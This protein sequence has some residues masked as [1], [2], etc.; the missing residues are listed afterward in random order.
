[1]P[2]P[3]TKG[4][5]PSNKEEFGTIVDGWYKTK[6]VKYKEGSSD[7]GNSWIKLWLKSKGFDGFAWLNASYNPSKLGKLKLLKQCLGL[8]DE[9]NDP[10]K[11]I[12]GEI[13]A[14]CFTDKAGWGTANKIGDIKQSP[15]K[16]EH[17]EVFD[18]DDDLPF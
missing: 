9:E 1:M 6:I 15:P 10:E 3:N 2:L 17:E 7:K 16:E 18:D 14:Y 12:D 8:S 4:V 11:F 5:E 13:W